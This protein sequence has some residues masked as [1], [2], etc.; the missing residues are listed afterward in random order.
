MYAFLYKCFSEGSLISQ[1]IIYYSLM[2]FYFFDLEICV[3]GLFNN[4]RERKKQNFDSAFGRTIHFVDVD[5]G[6][7]TREVLGC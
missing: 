6:N 4:L 7:G 1:D 5:V 2:Y 3:V